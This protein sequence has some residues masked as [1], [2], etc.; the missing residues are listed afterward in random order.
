MKHVVVSE[1]S[2]PTGWQ[3]INYC[4]LGYLQTCYLVPYCISTA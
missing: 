4:G 2:F 3:C 1:I